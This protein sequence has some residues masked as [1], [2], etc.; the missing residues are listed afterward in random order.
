MKTI[1]TLFA[2]LILTVSLFA[3]NHPR[4]SLVIRSA[5]QNDI[6]V[7]IDGRRFEPNDF[8]MSIRDLQPGYHTVKVYRERNFGIFTIFGQ[9]YD[10]VFNNTIVMRPFSNLMIFID[11]FGRSRVIDSRNRGGREYDYQMRDLQHDHDFDFGNGRNFGDYGDRDRNWNDRDSRWGD[12]PNGQIG[13]RDGQ[14]DNQGRDHDGRIDDHGYDDNS[15]NKTMSDFEFNRVLISIDKEWNENNKMR[16]ATQI[17]STN[18]F[19]TA[20]VKQM[21]LLFSSENNK[22]DLA[23]LAYSKTVDQRNYFMINDVFSFSSS[24]DELARYI[25]SH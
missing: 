4:T 10:M 3:G 7:I 17:I 11:R 24:K 12:N 25:R 16:S 18:F 20:Q 14:W 15:Y 13:G 1:F 9:R 19:T 2:S 22:L 6:R 5:D 8:H 21:L 23:K